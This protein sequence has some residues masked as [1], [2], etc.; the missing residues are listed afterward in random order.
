M[1]HARNLLAALFVLSGWLSGQN[2]LDLSV[3][4]TTIETEDAST[5]AA[6]NAPGPTSTDKGASS[7]SRTTRQ[8]DQT[9]PSDDTQWQD[10]AIW[11]D[12]L[13]S[14]I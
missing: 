10:E 1:R 14:D 12:F 6:T 4:M 8:V 2:I 7:S 5:A 9:A 3:P 13:D 11:D